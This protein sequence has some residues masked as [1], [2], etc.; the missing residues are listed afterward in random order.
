MSDRSCG[1][2]IFCKTG[3]LKNQQHSQES[4]Y[5]LVSFDKVA[6]NFFIKKRLQHWYFSVKIARF[7]RTAFV[8]E[9]QWLLSTWL[10]YIL[11]RINKLTMCCVVSACFCYL[12]LQTNLYKRENDKRKYLLMIF[13]YFCSWK[14]VL[15][16]LL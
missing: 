5:V 9:H 13:F 16:V 2:Q 10:V 14:C 7:F 8:V 3:I 12:Q 6:L 15:H 1:S 4:T 11:W